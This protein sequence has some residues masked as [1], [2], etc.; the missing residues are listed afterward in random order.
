MNKLFITLYVSLLQMVDSV[1]LPELL[2]SGGWEKIDSCLK[3]F[4]FWNM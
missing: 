4:F 2:G 1:V 3:S